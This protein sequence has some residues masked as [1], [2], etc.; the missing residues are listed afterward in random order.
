M[1]TQVIT[2][3]ELLEVEL[4]LALRR[5]QINGNLKQSNA[6]QRKTRFELSMFGTAEQIIDQIRRLNDML[7]KEITSPFRS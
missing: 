6:T 5:S 4:G 7:D 1:P 2:P 3:D